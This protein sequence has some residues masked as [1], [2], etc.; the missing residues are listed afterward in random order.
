MVL[1]GSRALVSVTCRGLELAGVLKV[2][3]GGLCRDNYVL[4]GRSSGKCQ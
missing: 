3:Q 4:G 2:L 1:S